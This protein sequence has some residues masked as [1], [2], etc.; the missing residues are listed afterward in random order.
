MNKFEAQLS[1][2]PAHGPRPQHYLMEL[3]VAPDFV[4]DDLQGGTLQ[5]AGST[6]QSTLALFVWALKRA[7]WSGVLKVHQ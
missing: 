5:I 2:I 3:C 7:E 6:P 4:W 1:E